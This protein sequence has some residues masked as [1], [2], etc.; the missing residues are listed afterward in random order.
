MQGGEARQGAGDG[1]AGGE[2]DVLE[3]VQA[4]QRRIQLL[5]VSKA[6]FVSSC[7]S[8]QHVQC[9]VMGPEE[10]PGSTK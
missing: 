6:C 2:R 8:H 1:V 9:S 4:E 5:L 3:A 7:A 10:L